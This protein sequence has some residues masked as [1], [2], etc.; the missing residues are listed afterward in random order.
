MVPVSG[1]MVI[2]AARNEDLKVSVFVYKHSSMGAFVGK[3]LY[4]Q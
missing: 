2:Q 3:I 1:D 4:L